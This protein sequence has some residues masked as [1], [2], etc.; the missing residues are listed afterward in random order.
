MNLTIIGSSKI[1]HEH[2]RAAKANKFKICGIYSSRKNSLN[3]ITLKNKFKIKNNFKN[4]MELIDFSVKNNCSILLAGRISDNEK[5]LKICMQNNI[6]VLIEKPVFCNLKKYKFFNKYKNLIFVGYNRIFYENIQILKKKLRLK[7]NLEVIINCPE[8][9]IKRIKTNSSHIVSIILYLFPD[10]NIISIKRNATNYFIRFQSSKGFINLFY[11][12]Q[13]SDNFRFSIFLNK[14]K[15]IMSPI[16]NLKIFN[17]IDNVTTNNKKIYLPRVVFNKNEFNY[18]KF[19]PGFL[20]QMNYFKKFIKSEIKN[21][22]DIDFAY[23][24]MVICEK[25]IKS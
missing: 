8:K 18:S 14:E 4:I 22:P 20:K 10:A 2:I 3:A 25:I 6:K 24:V 16:E 5:F 17:G 19:K 7:K 11:H 15:I 13:C 9:N 23:K 21:F 1:V 12:I